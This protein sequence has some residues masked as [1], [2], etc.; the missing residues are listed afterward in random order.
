M[1]KFD[2][3]SGYMWGLC[4][5][6]CYVNGQGCFGQT[7]YE[8]DAECCSGSCHVLSVDADGGRH[9]QCRD[10]T[11]EDKTSEAKP[12]DQA[13]KSSCRQVN[14]ACAGYSQKASDSECCSGYC[15]LMTVDHNTGHMQGLCEEE[16]HLN[17]EDCFGLSQY[18]ADAQ[19][20]SGKCHV[21]S[22]DAMGG[23]HG[24]CQAPPPSCQ[25][26]TAS[27]AGKTFADADAQCCS[28]NCNDL[29][30]V[31]GV[32]YGTCLLAKEER[33]LEGAS[34]EA[35]APAEQADAA[36][37]HCKQVNQACSGY[38]QK[39]GNGQCCSGYCHLMTVDHSTGFMQGLCE[40]QCY[41]VN[42]DCFGNSQYEANGQCCSGYC[43]VLSVDAEGGRHGQCKQSAPAPEPTPEPTPS[44]QPVYEACAGKTFGDADAQCC[45]GNCNDLTLRN[46]VY[47]G[48]CLLDKEERRLEGASEEA[49]APAEQADA[50]QH[51]CKQVNQACSGYSQDQGNGQCCSGYCHLM[52][53]DQRTGFMQ[54]LCEEQCYLDNHGCFGFSDYEANGQC[55]S[56]YCNV[57]SVDTDGGRHGRCQRSPST[58]TPEPTPRCQP[59]YEACA[60]KT[61]A[62]ADAQCCSGNCNDL[63]LRDGVYYGTCVLD[64]E[65]RRLEGASEEA[66]APAEQADSAQHH[67]KQVNQNCSGYSQA[68]GNGQCCSGYCHLMT[69]DHNTGF[70]RGLCEE[71]CYLDNHD[72]F[73]NSQLEA[74]GQCCSGY[75]HVLSVDADGGRH[76]RCQRSSPAPEPTPQPTSDCRPLDQSCAGRTFGQADDQC[77][78]GNCNHLT[79]VDGVYY[80]HCEAP[81]QV[82][83]EGCSGYS[84]REA[85]SMCCSGRCDVLSTAADGHRWGRCVDNNGSLK[86]VNNL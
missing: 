41:L 36:Q 74:N 39:A 4:E 9:G 23:R 31:D 10:P 43:H 18:Q 83:G 58:P 19:C 51:H 65:E 82:V 73:G 60:G 30:L 35:Q 84:D 34:E 24:T 75:C 29:N 6:Q 72:C 78:S 79:F 37:H 40:E 71:Q 54:G 53:V 68:E 50:T 45:S 5:E 7:Q 80:G 85:D 63:T 13:V 25:P 62:A 64:K 66:Q 33:R 57:L 11:T 70:M 14:Q 38:S 69:V 22:V 20:C 17:N 86:A 61:F 44:C 42:H 47:Y 2:R 27:C 32:Y 76:G 59:V 12:A 81:C 26:V 21:L 16:C 15:H 55:C 49:Q 48:T 67:C 1:M 3:D 56:G 46:G 8:A 77:C 28:K 52:T